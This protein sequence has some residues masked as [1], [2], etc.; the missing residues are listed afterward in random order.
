[1][2]FTVA[3]VLALASMAMAYPSNGR[4]S[5]YTMSEERYMLT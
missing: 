4:P 1:M 2:K 3:A 5:G